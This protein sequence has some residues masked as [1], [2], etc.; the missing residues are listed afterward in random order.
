MQEQRQGIRASTEVQLLWVE[1]P[2]VGLHLLCNEQCLQQ[3]KPLTLKRLVVEV[4]LG[5]SLAPLT[6]GI[7]IG[8]DVFRLGGNF[9]ILCAGQ[10]VYLPRSLPS[11][12]D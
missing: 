3:L 6:A 11:L 8:L 10:A 1:D 4:D 7:C 12:M 5:S 9:F 2:L